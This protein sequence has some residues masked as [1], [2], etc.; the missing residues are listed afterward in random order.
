MTITFDFEPR[1]GPFGWFV[2]KYFEHIGPGLVEAIFDGW[3]E[4]IRVRTVD[5]TR[6][7]TGETHTAGGVDALYR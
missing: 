1:Y 4:E 7:G 5:E 2:S 3:E 6:R